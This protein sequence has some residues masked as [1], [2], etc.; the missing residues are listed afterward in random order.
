MKYCQECGTPLK[1]SAVYCYVC[2]TQ[3]D[4]DAEI[5]D[6][7][8]VHENYRRKVRAE[9]K[10]IKAG[11]RN[12]RIV[13]LITL[14][15]VILLLP[16]FISVPSLNLPNFNGIHLLNTAE[17]EEK[18]AREQNESRT[19]QERQEL[20][21]H[22]SAMRSQAVE[23]AEDY[24]EKGYYKEA[25]EILEQMRTYNQTDLEIQ[26]LLTTATNDYEAFVRD[27][28]Q[29][30]LENEDWNGAMELLERAVN[31]LPDNAVIEQLYTTTQASEN[32]YQ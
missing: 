10:R 25:I 2:G 6:H 15:L 4:A 16:R 1:E 9:E 22:V 29:I 23:K 7:A 30:Y 26:T 8:A 27:Q 31:D 18:A 28:V 17:Q 3:Y 11:K 32:L 24:I 5:Q 14:V 19:S 20:Q 13:V 21:E 12:R